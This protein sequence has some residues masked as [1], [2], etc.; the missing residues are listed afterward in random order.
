MRNTLRPDEYVSVV[1]R[2]LSRLKTQR[3]DVSG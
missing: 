2:G 1:T 3:V